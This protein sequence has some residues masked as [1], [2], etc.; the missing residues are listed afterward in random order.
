MQW[1]LQN[2]AAWS[3]V[4]VKNNSAVQG[5][6]QLSE[7]TPCFSP[8]RRRP[9]TASLL[10]LSLPDFLFFRNNLI[11]I[12]HKWYFTIS[13]CE[14]LLESRNDF[15]ARTRFWAAEI[16]RIEKNA[17]SRL[18]VAAGWRSCCDR[19]VILFRY[20]LPLREV[21][22]DNGDDDNGDDDDDNDDDDDDLI[23]GHDKVWMK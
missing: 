20:N 7:K 11:F 10:F 22:L 6:R 8:N 12:N 5:K 2:I 16:A 23:F 14:N 1:C 9:I 18:N 3:N 19:P 21:M 15:Y 17:F 4:V 13:V